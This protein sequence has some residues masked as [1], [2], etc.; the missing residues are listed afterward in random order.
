MSFHYL[1]FHMR[2][3][4]YL[5]HTVILGLCCSS[6][7]CGIQ[8]SRLQ[9]SSSER[10]RGQKP[11]LQTNCDCQS[12]ASAVRAS[13][14]SGA[15]VLVDRP[16]HSRPYSYCGP[17]KNLLGTVAHNGAISLRHGCIRRVA[18]LDS[19]MHAR[20]QVLIQVYILL[21]G[22]VHLR[23][24]VQPPPQGTGGGHHEWCCKHFGVGMS[25][26][27]SIIFFSLAT[28]KATDDYNGR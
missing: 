25:L 17:P 12:L 22:V 19:S 26:R 21:S 14:D 6:S 1:N 4:G 11:C 2:Y 15:A 28:V 3:W 10:V 7:N 23:S 16:D 13:Y 24:I 20:K 18:V 9:N 8:I 5:S 27:M